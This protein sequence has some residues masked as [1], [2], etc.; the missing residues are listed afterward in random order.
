MVC[1]IPDTIIVFHAVCW[2]L[3]N[4]T[5]SSP[6]YGHYVTVQPPAFVVRQFRLW[7]RLSFGVTAC[8]QH[9]YSFGR[10]STF[11][12]I[13]SQGCTNSG[14]LNFNRWC[15]IFSAL[16]PQFLPYVRNYASDDMD[17]AESSW[18]QWGS[19]VLG[20]FRMELASC[21]PSGA[22]NLESAYNFFL[23]ICGS[24]CKDFS[25]QP[26]LLQ[27]VFWGSCFKK[28]VIFLFAGI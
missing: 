9:L 19:Q 27:N 21:Q 22:Y 17:R 6:P 15:P 1:C 28:H 3:A 12:V 23:E 4:W 13:V 26:I 14:C 2:T 16:L 8:S 11:R 25:G 5:T 20:V 24:L 7:G 18:W 10:V